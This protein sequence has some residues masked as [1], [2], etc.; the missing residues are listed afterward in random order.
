[1]GG[2]SELTGSAYLGSVVLFRVRRRAASR[3]IR[4]L[5]GLEHPTWSTG[6]RWG[7][8]TDLAYLGSKC[9][10]DRKEDECEDDPHRER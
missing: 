9:P 1:M 7:D 2:F 5:S 8:W 3:F 6:Y 4:R 10:Q